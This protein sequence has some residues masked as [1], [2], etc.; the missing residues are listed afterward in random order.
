M[1]VILLALGIAAILFMGGG[2]GI[3]YLPGDQP[4]TV[5]E[6]VKRLTGAVNFRRV[7]DG[8]AMHGR[9]ALADAAVL[10]T[11]ELSAKHVAATTINPRVSR[12]VPINLVTGSLLVR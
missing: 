3:A 8:V 10:R 4:P 9:L 7:G 6:Y 2:L 1:H 11:T 12:V 5:A